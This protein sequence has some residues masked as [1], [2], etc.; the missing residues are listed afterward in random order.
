MHAAAGT[1]SESAAGVLLR[2]SPGSTLGPMREMSNERLCHQRHA[3][4]LRLL[5]RHGMDTW[6]A[7]RALQTGVPLHQT[8]DTLALLMH[9]PSRMLCLKPAVPP[10][11]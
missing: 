6:M 10:A 7:C 9:W 8:P 2:L 5:Q 3:A 11:G 1:T 4:D